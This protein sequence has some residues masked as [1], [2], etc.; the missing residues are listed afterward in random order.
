VTAINLGV[1]L[2]VTWPMSG[3]VTTA[4]WWLAAVGLGGF[5]PLA[6]AAL[7]ASYQRAEGTA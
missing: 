5:V 4:G 2:L 7:A 6:A 1:V 3:W